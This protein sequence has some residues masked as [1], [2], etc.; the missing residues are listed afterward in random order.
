MVRA[1]PRGRLL[2]PGRNPAP[3]L[4]PNRR[5]GQL[6]VRGGPVVLAGSA[7]M[8][9]RGTAASS[10]LAIGIDVGGTKAA[11]GIVGPDG[12]LGSAHRIENA[13][14]GGPEDLLACVAECARR[15]ASQVPAGSVAAVGVG[16]PELVDL[17][18]EVRS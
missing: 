2:C 9:S 10:A 17:G 6:L 8:S 16:L 13:E 1:A 5:T 15:L 18:G 11:L 12:V 4:Q 3:L 14:A 7:N